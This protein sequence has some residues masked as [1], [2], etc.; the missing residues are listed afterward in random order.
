MHFGRECHKAICT[1]LGVWYQE[2]HDVTASL[3]IAF[4]CLAA[5]VDFNHS[6]KTGFFFLIGKD[7]WGNTLRLCKSPTLPFGFVNGV[8]STFAPPNRLLFVC[9]IS[10]DFY[11]LIFINCHLIK[12]FP[13]NLVLSFVL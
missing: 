13:F 3:P 4:C 6:N 8:N 9:M 1:L 2:E 5:S 11:M 12:F 10:S 7:L